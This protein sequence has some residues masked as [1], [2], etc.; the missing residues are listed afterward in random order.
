[1]P[2]CRVC[3]NKH[4]FGSSQVPPVAPT[5]NGPVSGL[6][7]DFGND[8]K[9]VSVTRLGAGK[10]TATA[11]GKEPQSYFDICPK[12]GSQDIEWQ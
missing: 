3:R 8:G 7:G 1:M 2:Y 12:C 9:L 10:S 4:L 11:A 6:L 5:A